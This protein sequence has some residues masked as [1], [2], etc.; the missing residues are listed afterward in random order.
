MTGV[1]E[2]LFLAATVAVLGILH[3]LWRIWNQGKIAYLVHLLD[4]DL[5]EFLKRNSHERRELLEERLKFQYG[6]FCWRILRLLRETYEAD[7]LHEFLLDRETR[8]KRVR[9]SGGRYLAEATGT[10]GNPAGELETLFIPLADLPDDLL[11]SWEDLTM[12]EHDIGLTV[13]E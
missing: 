12:A 13:L 6:V 11:K 8:V 1:K 4:V 7:A 2:I 5:V 3:N 10:H 9:R